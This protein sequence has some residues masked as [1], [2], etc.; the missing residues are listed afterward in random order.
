VG[1]EALRALAF[2]VEKAGQAGDLGSVAARMDGL[3]REVAR[4]D[5]AMKK[6]P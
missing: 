1:G 6:E 4:L 3:A 5:E 2:E